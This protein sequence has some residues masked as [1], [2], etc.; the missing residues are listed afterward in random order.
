MKDK[1]AFPAKKRKSTS[2]SAA[3]EAQEEL[4]KILPLFDTL[5]LRISKL[6]QTIEDANRDWSDYRKGDRV[7]IVDRNACQYGL[8]GIVDKK[9]TCYVWIKLNRPFQGRSV[10]QKSKHLVQHHHIYHSQTV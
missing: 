9:T 10:L 7:V 1:H 3:E 5:S 8:E 6:E 4:D 2:K